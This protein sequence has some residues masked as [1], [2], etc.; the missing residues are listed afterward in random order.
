MLIVLRE[1]KMQSID[2]FMLNT[3]INNII[4]NKKFVHFTFDS[5][6]M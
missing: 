3:Y 4:Y 5:F 2:C 1:H 6:N